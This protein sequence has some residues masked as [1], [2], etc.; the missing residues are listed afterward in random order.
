MVEFMA[1][2]PAK[3]G[4]KTPGAAHR[5]RDIFGQI[6]HLC[7]PIYGRSP[8]FGI[9]EIR[10]VTTAPCVKRRVGAT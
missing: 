1:T 7:C 8:R 4:A 3:Y 6:G 9:L 2:P 10:L 5:S